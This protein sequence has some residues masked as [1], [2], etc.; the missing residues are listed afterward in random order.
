MSTNI[1]STVPSSSVSIVRNKS[2]KITG[3]R[4]AFL[5]D[6]TKS[7]LRAQ[8]RDVHGLKGNALNQ[9]VYDMTHGD[10]AQKARTLGRA[11]FN[12]ALDAGMIP[13]DA[14][15]RTSGNIDFKLVPPSKE[16][17]ARTVACVDVDPVAMVATLSPEQKAALLAALQA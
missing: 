2:G 14:L 12:A 7:S 13:L 17:K 5:G 9:W 16:P 1:L 4:V 3:E 8:G 6:G 10:E 15:K 11:V